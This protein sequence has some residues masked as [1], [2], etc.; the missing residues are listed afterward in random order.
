MYLN[1]LYFFSQLDCL[2]C[3]Y[4]ITSV[5]LLSCV[6]LFVTP[7]IAES[8]SH[9]Q[10]FFSSMYYSPLDSSVHGVFQTRLLEWVAI[11]SFGGSSLS[12]DRTWFSCISCTAGDFFTRKPLGKPS[13]IHASINNNFSGFITVYLPF[14]YW[15]T[16][17]LHLS[18]D[19]CR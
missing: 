6:R 1:F 5:Q 18:S 4:L 8:L 2:V 16:P 12:R 10:L 15:S 13:V 9:I 17:W 19:I 14:T 3:C 7:W 11:S